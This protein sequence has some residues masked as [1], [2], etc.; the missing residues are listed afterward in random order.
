MQVFRDTHEDGEVSSIRKVAIHEDGNQGEMVG[1]DLYG[2]NVTAIHNEAM[3]LD[4]MSGSGHTPELIDIDDDTLRQ[5]DVGITE[6]PTDGE[7]WRRH[8]IWMLAA[9]RGRGVRHGDLKGNNIITIRNYPWAID[10]QESHF[11]GDVAPQK[12]PFSDASLLMQHIEGTLDVN[13]QSDIPR[14]ARR[15]RAVL[16]SLG[17]V[18]GLTL[19]LKGKVFVDLGCFQGDF[20]AL[21]AAEGMDATGFDAGGFRQGENSIKIGRDHWAGFPF[22]LVQLIEADII[23]VKGFCDVAMMFS[24]WPYVVQQHGKIAAEQLLASVIETAEVFFFECQLYG[25]G[26]GPDFLKTDDDIKNMLIWL[27]ATKITPIAKF[28]VT[29]RPG[30]RTIWRVDG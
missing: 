27:G 28:P 1:V 25:D 15:W 6:A 29:G 2:L 13:N 10:W 23:D 11:I 20:V 21:A 26:P 12:T 17:A 18:N 16:G 5:E 9:I 30:L 3:M 19:P 7:L 14:V 22:G 4:A 8:L 24:T